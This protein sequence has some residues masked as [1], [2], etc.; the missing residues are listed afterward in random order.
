MGADRDGSS[1]G[2]G[3]SS[4]YVGVISPVPSV[5]AQVG[6]DGHLAASDFV[7]CPGHGDNKIDLNFLSNFLS[8]NIMIYFIIF[9][10]S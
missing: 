3:Q 6:K 7:L 9:Y 1:L 10:L 8:N 4:V 5:S 2:L